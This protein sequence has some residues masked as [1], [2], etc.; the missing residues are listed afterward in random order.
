MTAPRKA[1]EPKRRKA[2]RPVV[3]YWRV[4]GRIG[5][6][7]SWACDERDAP[8]E[9]ARHLALAHRCG[10]AGELVQERK[11]VMGIEHVGWLP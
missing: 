9:A 4:W 7:L 3:L 2:V 11:P 6:H 10:I 5:E 8:A 1:T